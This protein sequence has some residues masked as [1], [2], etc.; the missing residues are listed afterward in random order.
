[1]STLTER[2]NLTFGEKDGARTFNNVHL[3][4]AEYDNLCMICSELDINLD[5]VSYGDFDS[6]AMMLCDFA[7]SANESTGFTIS[8]WFD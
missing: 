7:N 6:C 2:M 5:D 8:V 3:G 1:M 4:F